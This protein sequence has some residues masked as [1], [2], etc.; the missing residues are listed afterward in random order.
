LD[1]GNE[2]YKE[3]TSRGALFY[4]GRKWQ[5][6]RGGFFAEGFESLNRTS[7]TRFAIYP[8]GEFKR[9]SPP[10]SGS[11]A[12]GTNGNRKVLEAK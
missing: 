8:I 5:L 7:K 3:C 4:V 12:T 6:K 9:R 2:Y 1:K 11:L 10:S